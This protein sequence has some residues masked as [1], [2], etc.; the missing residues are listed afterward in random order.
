MG[1]KWSLVGGVYLVGQISSDFFE[2]SQIHWARKKRLAAHG[3]GISILMTVRITTGAKRWVHSESHPKSHKNILASI[4]FTV[5]LKR[6]VGPQHPTVR[7]QNRSVRRG[8]VASIC[9]TGCPVRLRRPALVPTTP[10]QPAWVFPPRE[11]FSDV[12]IFPFWL[13]HSCF[14]LFE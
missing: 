3:S 1:K 7:C 8:I 2:M 4:V 12:L 5:S 6:F 14:G 11:F 10:S 9:L 13:G